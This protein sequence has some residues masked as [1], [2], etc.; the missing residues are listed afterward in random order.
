MSSEGV[1]LQGYVSVTLIPRPL[2]VKFE[3]EFL[4]EPVGFSRYSEG[5]IYISVNNSRPLD[6]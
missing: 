1:E 5:S 2:F 6:S 4:Y 3:D